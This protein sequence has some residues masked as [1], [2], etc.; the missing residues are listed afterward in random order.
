M[1]GRPNPSPFDAKEMSMTDP[2]PAHRRSPERDAGQA[3]ARTDADA[4][5]AAVERAARSGVIAALEWAANNSPTWA[6]SQ[7]LRTRAM[8]GDSVA[9]IAA[10]REAK[11][12]THD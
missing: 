10:Y 2:T 5:E 7:F 8:H 9:A 11:E 6:Y 12:A 4:K 3:I 1:F